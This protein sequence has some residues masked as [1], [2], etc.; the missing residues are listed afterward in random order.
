MNN[1]AETPQEEK[2]L[3]AGDS[4]IAQYCRRLIACRPLPLS[5]GLYGVGILLSRV[6]G[7]GQDD[8]GGQ[9][10]LFAMSEQLV[11]L[12]E[13]G[14]L[15]RLF[16]ELPPIWPHRLA[17]LEALN[18]MLLNAPDTGD[19]SLVFAGPAP[20]ATRWHARYAQLD[21]VARAQPLL[22]GATLPLRAFMASRLD[23]YLACGDRRFGDIFLALATSWFRLRMLCALWAEAH[24]ELTEEQ[25]GR[26][27]AQLTGWEERCPPRAGESVTADDTLL[28][29]LSLL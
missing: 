19:L 8:A 12:A 7:G 29:G 17:A 27:M 13:E 1:T 11:L 9:M 25:A 3:A 21:A 23:D 20:D 15:Q 4:A 18:R 6:K 2:A 14:E 28:C 26:L 22:K 24:G 10:R 16:S 5:I